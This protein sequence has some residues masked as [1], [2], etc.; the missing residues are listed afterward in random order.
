MRIMDGKLYAYRTMAVCSASNRVIRVQIPL[1][2]N[3]ILIYF[4]LTALWGLMRWWNST[5]KAWKRF[6]VFSSVGRAP[7][8]HSGRRGFESF[9]TYS[10]FLLFSPFCLIAISCEHWDSRPS[11]LLWARSWDRI[12]IVPQ[13]DVKALSGCQIVTSV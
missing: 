1:R 11:Y 4:N 3:R 2:V 10:R 8:L 9:N 12:A 7:F 13:P 5:K 6:K